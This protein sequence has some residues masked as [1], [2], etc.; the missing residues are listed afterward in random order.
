MMS[1]VRS[2]AWIAC[3]VT[4]ATGCPRAS[5]EPPAPDVSSS[6]TRSYRMGFSVIPPKPD[7][8]IALQ[9]LD[10]WTKRSD[11]A[12]MHLDVPWALL[13]AG[14]SPEDAL[15]KDGV[16]LERYYRSKH[17]QLVVTI[18]VTNGL[19]RESEAPALVAAHRS[20]T[21]PAV[22]RLYRDY[23]RALVQMLRPDY[24]GL[25]AETNL[26][27]AIAPRPIYNAVVRMTNEDRKSVV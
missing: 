11:A 9:S 23:V 10:I 18:D 7:L 3:V 4:A 20:I 19:G 12:I 26:V 22:Q 27:R 25:A 14:T 2:W 8:K 24:L 15:R 21:E 13:L 16:D 6:G 5:R 17:L 1:S